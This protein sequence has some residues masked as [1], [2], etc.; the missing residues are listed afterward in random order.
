[1]RA[2]CPRSFLVQHCEWSVGVPTASSCGQDD[3]T[4]FHEV[5]KKLCRSGSCRTAPPT[6]FNPSILLKLQVRRSAEV[7]P[8][9]VHDLVP[10]SDK[11]LLELFLGVLAGVDFRK[12]PE[13]GV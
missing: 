8:I 6:R 4:P 2:R 5:R 9:Q 10:G 7:E 12:R 13:L 3:S 11:V 1:M